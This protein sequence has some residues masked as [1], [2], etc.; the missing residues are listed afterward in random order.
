ML[1]FAISGMHI[2]TGY[3]R[4]VSAP[5]CDRPLE[6]ARIDTPVASSSQCQSKP[7][8]GL[9]A[10]EPSA[11]ATAAVAATASPPPPPPSPPSPSPSPPIPDPA[12]VADNTDEEDVELQNILQQFDPQTKP[13]ANR[14]KKLNKRKN[15]RARR[16]AEFN[17]K[18]AAQRD[19]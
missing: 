7:I 5:L 15:R 11:A 6:T 14:K 17:E 12:E 3:T 16:L 19:G 4:R 13:P 18:F 10:H 9:M 8:E 1:P 2:L